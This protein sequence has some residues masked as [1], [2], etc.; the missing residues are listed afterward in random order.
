[1]SKSATI[2]QNVVFHCWRLYAPFVHPTIAQW[3]IYHY[4]FNRDIH[5]YMYTTQQRCLRKTDDLL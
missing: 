2:K 1:M 3:G 4:E 5:V